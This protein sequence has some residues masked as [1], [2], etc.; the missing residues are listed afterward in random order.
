MPIN[1]DND[2]PPEQKKLGPGEHV[3]SVERIMCGTTEK[4]Y[5]V[6]SDG[7]RKILVVLVGLDYAEA[8]YDCPVEGRSI[9]K[10]NA[11]LKAC[12]WSSDIL[13][14]QGVE[15]ADF[16][17]QGVADRWLKGKRFRCTI[18]DETNADS[19]K[20]FTNVSVAPVVKNEP[21]APTGTADDEEI[22]F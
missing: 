14:E 19:G 1:T 10:L 20:T 12:G 3:V 11:M 15:Y 22:P 17:E 5:K 8:I 9:W 2:T 7:S 16:L 18:K 21:K 6:K 4:R 13:N